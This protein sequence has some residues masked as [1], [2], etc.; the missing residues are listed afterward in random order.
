M[1]R[2]AGE[3]VPTEATCIPTD[4]SYKVLSKSGVAVE[5][6]GHKTVGQVPFYMLQHCS[7][8][9]VQLDPHN[10]TFYLLIFI[11]A[12]R[13][14]KEVVKHCFK[15]KSDPKAVNYTTTLTSSFVVFLLFFPLVENDLFFLLFFFF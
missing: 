12:I 3:P 10:Q 6:D 8:N 5:L 11:F 7:I 15:I 1:V 14:K 13:K 4:S 2:R 9:Q